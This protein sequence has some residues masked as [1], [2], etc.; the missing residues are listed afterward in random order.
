M[1]RRRIRPA[2]GTVDLSQ[3]I[4]IEQLVDEQQIG[5]F[6]VSLLFWSFLAMFTDGYD[7]TAMSFAAPQLVKLWHLSPGAMKQ[8]LVASQYGVLL[9]APLMGWFGDRFGRRRA[10]IAGCVI[11]G[12]GTLAMMAASDLTQMFVL[13]AATGLG[14]GGLM[15]NTIALNSELAPRRHRAMLVVLMFTGITL[16]SGT[17]GFVA[18]WLVP[19]YGWQVLFLI[20]GAVPLAIAACLLFTLPESAKFLALHPQRRVEL[21][22]L[23]RRLRPDL[24]IGDDD[25]FVAATSTRTAAGPKAIFAG[26][27]ALITPLLWLCFITVFMSNFFLNNWLPL[28]FQSNG[29]SVKAAAWSSGAYHVGATL[30]GLLVSLLLGRYGFALIALL[31]ALSVPALMAIGAPGIS[32][33]LLSVASGAAGFGV[34][35]AQFGNNASSGLLYPTAIRS[36]GSGWAFGVGR[37]GSIAGPLL[38]GYLIARHWSMPALFMAASTPM[39]VGMLAAVGLARLCYARYGSLRIEDTPAAPVTVTPVR[40]AANSK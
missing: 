10:I 28:V 15:P 38:G 12:L 7:I 36:T 11:F 22:R 37:I 31:F 23:A 3:L 2:E 32:L 20:G 5:R 13:R 33:G 1:Q 18:G 8:V 40:I 21:V 27:L 6:N 4:R 17:P 24:S 30:A 9:G 16:G 29:L 19:L 25:R 26:G 14:L 39:L 35:G 34:L